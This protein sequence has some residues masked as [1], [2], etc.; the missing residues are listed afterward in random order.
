MNLT[1]LAKETLADVQEHL[2]AGKKQAAIEAIVARMML[3]VESATVMDEAVVQ[4]DLDCGLFQNAWVSHP[5]LAEA[6]ILIM[7]SP[8]VGD[9]D[10]EGVY[11]DDDRVVVQVIV[12]EIIPDLNAVYAVIDQFED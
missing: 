12:P 2:G 8:T 4:I 10:G 9:E 3:L 6:K 5:L 7:E 1:T 11:L